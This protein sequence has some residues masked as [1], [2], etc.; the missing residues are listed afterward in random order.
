MKTRFLALAVLFYGSCA[1]AHSGSGHGDNA[2]YYVGKQST[3]LG[4]TECFVEATYSD[5]GEEV[6]VRSILTD[7]HSGE[8]VGV[9]PIDADYISSDLM[10]SFYDPN[11]EDVISLE[12]V[13]KVV[14]QGEIL[15]LVL[16]HGTHDHGDSCESL[17]V[18]IDQK[19]LAVEEMFHHFDDYL[20]DQ[21]HH[22]QNFEHD[23]HD[24]EH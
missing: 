18:A 14:K 22:D 10:Y 7:G 3:L 16:N 15:N 9:G 23:D 12:L 20:E 11:A 8:L 17:E 21:D 19:L 2:V 13:A 5:D 6:I 1:L 24:H 4:S